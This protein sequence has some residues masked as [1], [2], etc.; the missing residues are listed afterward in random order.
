MCIYRSYT[1]DQV[2][3][4]YYFGSLKSIHMARLIA[5]VNGPI[6]GKLGNAVAATW[7]GRPY[8]RSLPTR[9]L[10]TKPPATPHQTRFKMLHGWLQPVL[11]YVREGF[12][13]YSETVE[14]YNAAKSYNLR[15]AFVMDKDKWVLDPS[16]VLV[17]HGIVPLPE[18][19]GCYIDGKQLHFRWDV[20]T[21]IYNDQFDQAMLLAYDP[22]TRS[23]EFNTTG[24]FRKTGKAIMTI[25]RRGNYHVYIAFRAHNRSRQSNSQY[26]GVVTVL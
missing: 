5:G 24:E 17:S 10:K 16:L 6:S 2:C 20:E 13:G 15:N 26:L 8:L 25:F 14:G 21:S 7:K 19:I 23:V 11:D 18:N 22:D 1:V 9:K 12:K 4:K 3:L